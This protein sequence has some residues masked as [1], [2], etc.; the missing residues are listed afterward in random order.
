[1]AETYCG[2]SCMECKQKEMLNCP[3]CKAGPGKQFEVSCEL[4]KCCRTKGHQEC[5]TCGF[6]TDCRTL[7]SK[8]RMPVDRLKA[9]EA[10]RKRI[11]EVMRKAPI[12]GKWLWILF[13]LFIPGEIASLLTNNNLVASSPSLNAVGRILGAVCVIAY[14]VIL[15][16]LTS[17]EEHYRTAG[18]CALIYGAANIILAYI[19]GTVG[20]TQWIL[21][22]SILA[23]IISIVGEYNG[24]TAHGEVLIG[25]DNQLS[26]KWS[27]L[28]KWYIGAYIAML[29]SIFVIA[30]SPLLGLLVTVASAICLIIVSILKLVYLYRTA[31]AFRNYIV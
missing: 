14:G 8:D 12:L 11:A 5:T 21:L 26:D 25:V 13:W 31:M 17:E 29:G 2:K 4:A 19:S 28:W 16:R 3:G 7:R 9:A 27:A 22:P 23:A 1:M 15:L 30:I 10:E 24:F 20:I 18:I 6:H